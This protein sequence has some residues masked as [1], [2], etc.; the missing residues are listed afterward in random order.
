[1][2]QLGVCLNNLGRIC[3]ERGQ[4]A[5]G[6]ALHRQAVALR[7]E[8]RG[9]HEETAFSLGNL[10]VAL[11]SAGQWDEAAATLQDSVSMYD[12]LGLG[13]GAEAQGYKKNLEIC[14]QARAAAAPT[15]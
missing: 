9:E 4:L 6:I 14:H 15:A 11:A 7:R 12:R 13:M 10:G 5:E 2:P 1:M 3:E 8:L